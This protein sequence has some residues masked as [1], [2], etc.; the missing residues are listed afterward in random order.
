M[1]KTSEIVYA[2]NN[3][4]TALK[5]STVQNISIGNALLTRLCVKKRNNKSF[6]FCIF[7]VSLSTYN[8][9]RHRRYAKQL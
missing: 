4:Q 2:S 7:E 5:D 1:N 3:S 6:L 8:I 9:S